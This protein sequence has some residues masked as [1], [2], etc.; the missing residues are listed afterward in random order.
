MVGR[1]DICS[2][3]SQKSTFQRER[4]ACRMH[5]KT[6][7]VTTFTA[8]ASFAI[9]ALT[10][11]SSGPDQSGAGNQGGPAPQSNIYDFTTSMYASDANELKIQ[12]ADGLLKAAGSSTDDWM[13]ESVDVKSLELDS[14]KYCAVDMN[15]AYAPD[16]IDK[17]AVETG[18]NVQNNI[19]LQ[20]EI[21]QILAEIEGGSTKHAD[22]VKAAGSNDPE[23][24]Y[25]Y[26]L[27]NYSGTE[28]AMLPAGV[29]LLKKLVDAKPHMI[30]DLDLNELESGAYISEDYKTVT[31]VKGCAKSS[32]DDDGTN[33]LKFPNGEG[34]PFAS[35]NIGS[36]KNGSIVVHDGSVEKYVRD[37]NGDWI[38]G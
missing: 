33:L 24:I 20:E 27:E 1:I 32:T 25:V 16:A 10:G 36:M 23:T 11:C 34:K 26:M 38:N 2:F 37:S 5:M 31:L 30:T 18:D 15:I 13:I 9:F 29:N 4:C 7:I 3:T 19:D 17:F 12:F 21:K 28:K 8:A 14:A 22:I 35:L 6:K